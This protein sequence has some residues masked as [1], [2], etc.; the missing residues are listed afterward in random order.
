MDPS[1]VKKFVLLGLLLVGGLGYAGFTYLY[2]PTAAEIAVLEAQ[3][4]TLETSNRAAKILIDQG[5][6][7][8]VE[9]RLS[10]ATD[11]LV[12]DEFAK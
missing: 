6:Q 10:E 1:Q 9:R 5:G 12:Q 7:A 8:E 3:L 11:G 2:K 4:E